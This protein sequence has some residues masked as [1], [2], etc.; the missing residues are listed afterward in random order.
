MNMQITR[1]ILTFAA[2]LM[3]AGCKPVETS[4]RPSTRPATRPGDYALAV[5]VNGKPISMGELN[6]ALIESYGLQ[7]AHL[8]IV[9]KL[10]KQELNDKDL[11]VTDDDVRAES[12]QTLQQMFPD[13]KDENQLK[14][15]LEQFLRQK[16]LSPIQWEITMRRNAALRKLAAKQVTVSD[17]EI[18]EEFE[19]QSG[20]KVVVRHIQCATLSDAQEILDKLDDG[21]D[22]V[23][24][25]KEFSTNPSAQD[26]GL[27]PPIGEDI[28]GVPPAIGEAAMNMEK[29]GEIS[30]P[31]Q[32]GTAFHV[33][34]LEKIIPPEKADFE[35]MKDELGETVR[36]RKIQTAQ[37]QILQKL[38]SSADIEY[39]NP[40]LKAQ[41]RQA[42]NP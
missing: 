7:T 24:L 5:R 25:A 35:K 14:I 3:L 6:D 33:L 12:T 10:I 37:R 39:V 13:I 1:K 36:R 26:G 41:Q 29:V 27:L 23:E 38:I 32:T 22:F 31:I 8:L 21:A 17:E 11:Q 20:K 40:V 15:L 9:E 2:A 4:R 18:R 30:N 42:K 19:H 16:Q 28:T 34:K